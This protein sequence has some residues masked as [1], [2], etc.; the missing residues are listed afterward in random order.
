LAAGPLG[1]FPKE[2]QGKGKTFADEPC[3]GRILT[4]P[5]PQKKDI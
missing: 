2:G 4:A 3:E 1:I 5:P